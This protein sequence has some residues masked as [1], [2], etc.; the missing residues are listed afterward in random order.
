MVMPQNYYVK[1][2]LS[3]WISGG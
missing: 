2:G 1:C 3:W